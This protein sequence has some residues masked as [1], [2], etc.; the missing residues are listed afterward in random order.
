MEII[1]NTVLWVFPFTTQHLGLIKKARD[2]GYDGVEIATENRQ[3]GELDKIRGALEEH[4]MKSALC[5]VFGPARS[6]LD[7]DPAVQKN[8]LDYIRDSIDVCRKIGA[9]ILVGP[10]YSTGMKPVLRAPDE[11]KRDWAACVRNLKEACKYAEDSG[12]RVALEPLN[13]YET[14]FINIAEDAVRLVSEVGSPALG[15]HLDTYHMN[16]EEKNAGEA[17]RRT[18][19]LLYHFHASESDRGT[20]GTGNVHWEE[21][22]GA[23]RDIGYRG[24]VAVECL[25]G[26]NV[27][28]IAEA[29]MIWRKYAPDVDSVAVDGLRFLRELLA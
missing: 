24:K 21:V 3:E 19:R 6:I 23:L 27:I 5:G 22:A 15:V 11:K 17:V 7:P 12:I 1:I 18:G 20:N 2:I 9:D 14:S 28:E 8:G 10:T 29:A 26:P 4:G 13:R 16:I 25:A